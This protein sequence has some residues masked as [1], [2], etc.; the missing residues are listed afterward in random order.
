MT[1]FGRAAQENDQ[2]RATLELRTVNH[3]FCDVKVKLP[4]AWM[5]L[6]Q[7]LV[8]RCKERLDRGRVELFAR[9]DGIGASEVEVHVDLEL[10]GAIVARAREVAETLGLEGLPT[11]AELLA[12]PGVLVTREA[13]VDA[14]AESELVL[15]TLDVALDRLIEMRSDEG[16]RL[17]E[18]LGGHIGRVSDL[19]DRIADAAAEV[20]ARVHARLLDRLGQLLDGATAIDPNRLAQEAAIAADR[21]AIDEEIARLRSHVAQARSLLELDEPVGRRLEFLVQEMG[22]E[23]NTI[24]SK[25]SET[26]IAGMAV[27]LKSVLEKIREQ[28]ANV[29]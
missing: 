29:E 11:T 19:L 1:G 9:R 2:V 7:V 18:D 23:A 6:E 10:A 27:E 4:R 21:A 20:P 17:G 8:G 22:R 13:S 28:A 16:A 24:G 14:S 3:R 15:A 12:M 25:A 5:G 26:S